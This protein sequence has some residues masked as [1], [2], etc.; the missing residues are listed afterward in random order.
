[1]CIHLTVFLPN[2]GAFKV[3]Y[4]LINSSRIEKNDQMIAVFAAFVAS[5][6]P[7]EG[8]DQLEES[9]KNKKIAFDPKSLFKM[10]ISNLQNLLNSFVARHVFGT[11]KIP[12]DYMKRI[13]F[14]IFGIIVFSLFT[15]LLFKKRIQRKRTSL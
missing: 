8:Q 12:E 7:F 11:D 9:L 6:L 15:F 14:T 13:R 3:R 10:F 2:F 4:T 5:I 1:M